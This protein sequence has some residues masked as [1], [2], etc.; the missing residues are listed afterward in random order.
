MGGNF[1]GRDATRLDRRQDVGGRDVQDLKTL[2]LGITCPIGRN[3]EQVNLAAFL[4]YAAC[5]R[6]AKENPF[7]ADA[8]ILQ[9]SPKAMNGYH[10]C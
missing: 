2:T 8:Q 3:D 10:Q 4:G 1:I 7:A 9:F 6:T 5:L